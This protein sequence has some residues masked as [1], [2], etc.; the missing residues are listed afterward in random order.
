M[1]RTAETEGKKQTLGQYLT[2]L[3]ELSQMTLREVEQATDKLVSN[4]Y[5]SQLEKDKISK[6]SPNVLHALA[7]VYQT[8]YEDLMA[9]AGYIT[10]EPAHARAATFSLGSVTEDEQQALMA[11]LAHLRSAKK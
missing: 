9:H 1:A 11:F 6:P 7:S 2:A 3:R 5:L 10:S 4:P 8:S